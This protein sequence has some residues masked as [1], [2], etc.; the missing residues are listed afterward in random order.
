[1]RA[2]VRDIVRGSAR[3]LTQACRVQGQERAKGNA[4]PRHLANRSITRRTLPFA[5]RKA[6]SVNPGILG[7]RSA[8]H[9]PVDIPGHFLSRSRKRT[10]DLLAI[11]DRLSQ[12]K[13]HLARRGGPETT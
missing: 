4:H 2:R 5:P 9:A 1:M 12:A 6:P 11:I 7:P 13:V 3:R 8:W 10:A